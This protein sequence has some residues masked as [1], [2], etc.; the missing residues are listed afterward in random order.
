VVRYDRVRTVCEAVRVSRVVQV[1]LRWPCNTDPGQK[2]KV[3]LVS[4][5]SSLLAD[6]HVILA[7]PSMKEGRS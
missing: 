3:R 1:G 4:T 5:V 2:A 7:F 6:F